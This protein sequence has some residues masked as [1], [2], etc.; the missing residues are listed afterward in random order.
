[1]YKPVLYYSMFFVTYILPAAVVHWFMEFTIGVSA[2][3]Q[4]IALSHVSRE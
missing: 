4:C 3:L 1:M 2:S